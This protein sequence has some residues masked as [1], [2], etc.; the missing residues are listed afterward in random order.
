[1][2]RGMVAGVIMLDSRGIVS[3]YATETYRLPKGVRTGARWWLQG[4]GLV[5]TSSLVDVRSA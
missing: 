5:T 2:M 4:V 1:M 3:V